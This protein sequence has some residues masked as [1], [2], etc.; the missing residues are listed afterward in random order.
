M[1]KQ[2]M[3]EKSTPMGYSSTEA[4]ALEHLG[5]ARKKTLTEVEQGRVRTTIGMIPE[6]VRSILD[7]GCGD[8][9]IMT[10]LDSRFHVAGVDY[11]LSSLRHIGSNGIR[12]S[13]GCLPFEDR[14]FDLV[15]CS[16]VLEHIPE[17]SYVPTLN[18][19]ERVS[20]RYILI[21]VPYRE[22]LRL[23][24]TKC[25]QCRAVFHAYGHYRAFSN[26]QLSSLFPNYKEVNTAFYG[27]RVPFQCEFLAVIRQKVF[28]KWYVFEEIT[29]CQNCG[30]TKYE[31]PRRNLIVRSI[32]AMNH[33]AGKVVP[34]WERAWAMKLYERSSA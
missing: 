8:G 33:L 15:L 16:E 21:T 2:P 30:N 24:F 9:R 29:A 22:K 17:A 20:K 7:V 10:S 6:H 28:D 18:E 25:Q 13:S 1:S 12:A 5:K 11:A 14:S 32:D 3:N 26:S 34:V 31:P 19:F 27:R 23:L 4:R